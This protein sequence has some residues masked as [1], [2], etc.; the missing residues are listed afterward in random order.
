MKE[1][2]ASFFAATKDF[3]T[4]KYQGNTAMLHQTVLGQSS[5]VV[6]KKFNSLTSRSEFFYHNENIYFMGL[7]VVGLF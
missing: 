5:S 2:A 6:T 7:G 4:H 1:K 3:R